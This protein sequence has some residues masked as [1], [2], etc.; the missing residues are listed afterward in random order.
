MSEKEPTDGQEKILRYVYPL[1][2][3]K[4]WLTFSILMAITAFFAV[5][6]SQTHVDAGYMKSVPTG[7]EYM[8]VFR[9]YRDDLGGANII[10]VALMSETG[11]D[12]YNEKFLG[13]LKSVTEDVFFLE[14]VRRSRVKSIFTPNVR[15]IEV[16]EGGLSGGN[17]VPANYLP[18]QDDDDVTDPA[19]LE[20]IQTHV[21]K[22]GI[23]GRLVAENEKGALVKAEL[24]DINPV[25]GEEI[26]YVDV[27]RALQKIRAKYDSED[28]SVHIIGFPM[29]VGS[30]VD[31]SME[32]AVFFAIT[33]GI[34]MFLLWLYLGSIKMSLLVLLAG[35]FCVVWEFGLLTLL[36]YGLDP[37]AILVPF[38][39]LVISV[40][41]GVQ[42]ANCWVRE[43]AELGRSSLDASI[44]TFRQLFIPG[45]VAL[46]TAIAGVL[47]ILLIPV[48]IIQE[49]ALNAAFG[50]GGM[51]IANKVVVPILLSWTH[52]KDPEGFRQKQL[53]RDAI[54]N[55]VWAFIAKVPQ[56][57]VAWPLLLFLGVVT[58]AALWNASFVQIGSTTPG[59]PT[60]RPDAQYNVDNRVITENFSIGTDQIKVMAVSHS[61]ACIHY[62]VMREIERFAWHMENTKG[63]QSTL[64]LPKVTKRVNMG[65]NE[66]WL[67]FRVL[68]RNSY[69]LGLSTTQVPTSTGLLTTDCSVM[70]VIIFTADHQAETINHIIASIMQFKQESEKRDVDVEFKLA[71]G[72]VGVMAATNDV[73][74]AKEFQVMFVVYAAIM[75]MIFISFRSISAVICV[76]LPLAL[77][78]L[79][80]YSV[81]VFTNVGL[82]VS[83]LPI[84]AIAVGVGVD[85]GVYL[86][87][88][89]QEGLR[90]FGLNIRDATFR[91]MRKNGKAVVFTAVALSISVSTWM[92]STLQFQIDMGILL[93]FI[94]SANLFGATIVLPALAYFFASYPKPEGGYT[95]LEDVD[96]LKA[97]Q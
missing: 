94:F 55:H 24:M 6:A 71:S 47:T 60:L 80:S 12:I 18:N 66:G 15:Y 87:S 50:L 82:K 4:R 23:I 29:V 54:Y 79:L 19:M 43:R 13:T 62:D 10:L 51:V 81:M 39:V 5:V 34:T 41:H 35:L 14:G 97:K 61:Q 45:F 78:T 48:Q 36:G 92:F 88:V 42:Y 59:A 65:F 69:L 17:V 11:E 67:N 86:Y 52:I 56:K 31:A 49:M 22:A 73:I 75:I 95:R 2:F 96:E 83:T 44:A 3:A 77:V 58:G 84:Q 40:S 30:I 38:L 20:L 68:P 72:N 25:T 70:P 74:E 27:Y 33:L 76:V 91:A 7:H 28:I 90:D 37:F 93:L 16:V 53:R 21:Q 1:I 89:L 9:E 57:S 26:D 63:V 85:Y 32:V 8:E 64:S 46:F